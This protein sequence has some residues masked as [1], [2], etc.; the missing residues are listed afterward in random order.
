MK[1]LNH[2]SVAFFYIYIK[3]FKASTEGIRVRIN[4]W[5]KSRIFNRALGSTVDVT[6]RTFMSAAVT[7]GASQLILSEQVVVTCLA[8][9]KEQFQPGGG[10]GGG[11]SSYF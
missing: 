5:F 6:D 7:S 4:Y 1:K 11:G 3:K 10:G 2:L 8:H 9:F